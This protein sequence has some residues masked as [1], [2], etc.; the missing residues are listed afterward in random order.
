MVEARETL[1]RQAL[2]TLRRLH[3]A[4]EAGFPQDEVERLRLLA[5]SLYQAVI[6]FQLIRAGKPPSTIH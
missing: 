3:A 4:E 5:D 1:M 2:E 6:D